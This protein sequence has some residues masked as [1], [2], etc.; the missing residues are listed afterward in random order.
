M[1][2][3]SQRTKPQKKSANLSVSIDLLQIAKEDNLN[4]SKMLEESL[5]AYRKNKYEKEWVELNR[6]AFDDYNKM[7]N[8]HGLYSDERRLF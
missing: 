7:V 4:L 6:K 2:L 1:R 8:E 3:A 5:Q